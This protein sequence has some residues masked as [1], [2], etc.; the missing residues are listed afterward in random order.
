MAV[1]FSK[2]NIFQILSIRNKVYLQINQI[3][4]TPNKDPK[5]QIL[6]QNW[7][8][9]VCTDLWAKAL[10]LLMLTLRDRKHGF[11]CSGKFGDI[12]CSSLARTVSGTEET[13]STIWF[14][15][16]QVHFHNDNIQEEVKVI[17]GEEYLTKSCYLPL[18]IILEYSY[19][20]QMRQQF[21]KTLCLK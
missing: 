8:S 17:M 2:L 5:P 18:S 20:L 6:L 16:P 9:H 4:L 1:K 11:K 21:F 19:T 13:R 3:S 15:K 7:V 10:I 14:Q 12:R